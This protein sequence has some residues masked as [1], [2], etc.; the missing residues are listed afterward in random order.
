LGLQ[1]CALPPGPLLRRQP[2][3][4]TPTPFCHGSC[5]TVLKVATWNLLVTLAIVI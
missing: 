5:C 1:C 3:L 2:S 4:R